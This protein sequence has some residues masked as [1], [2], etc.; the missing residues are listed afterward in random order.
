MTALP[1]WLDL[2]AAI[3]ARGLVLIP[4]RP[5]LN[6][7]DLLVWPE[8]DFVGW[9]NAAQSFGAIVYAEES[10]V[11]EQ[12]GALRLQLD[13][14]LNA[15][16]ESFDHDHDRIDFQLGDLA[17]RFDNERFGWGGEWRHDGVAH[18]FVA[19][20]L[21]PEIEAIASE[22]TERLE[23]APSRSFRRALR[24]DE[25]AAAQARRQDLQQR[26]VEALADHERFAGCRNNPE[27]KAL[28]R[29]F[30]FDLSGLN[31]DDLVALARQRQRDQ[32]AP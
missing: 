1:D 22:L 19:I 9:L 30:G 12:V 27:R 31:Q 26:V 28:L 10:A 3:E 17:A 20:E 18:A 6:N 16:G 29:S 21:P 11:D 4:R 13:D 15:Y 8:E 2:F 25:W 14:T 7:V 24:E 23:A 32:P 5:S